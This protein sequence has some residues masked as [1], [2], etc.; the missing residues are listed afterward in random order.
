MK[1][2]FW[3]RER[4]PERLTGE[5]ALSELGLNIATGIMLDERLETIRAFLKELRS[6]KY[7]KNPIERVRVM[8]R[9]IEEAIIPY[10]RGRDNPAFVKLINSW[11]KIVTLYEQL[12]R[13]EDL[14]LKYLNTLNAMSLKEVYEPFLT[15]LTVG[16]S[17]EDLARNIV[18]VIQSYE[19][20]TAIPLSQKHIGVGKQ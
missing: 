20:P 5:E 14:R 15:I 18:A 19:I 11:S 8:K 3:G 1:L 17:K 16:F 6:D 12:Y 9:I 4:G 13:Y 10:G 7:N 2:K